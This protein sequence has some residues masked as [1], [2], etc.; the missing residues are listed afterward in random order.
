MVDVTT[1]LLGDLTENVNLLQPTGVAVTISKTNYP[2]LQFFAQ[3]VTIPSLS[4]PEAE[5]GYPRVNLPLPGDKITFDD[6]QFSILVDED[7]NS[8]LELFSWLYRLINEE[9]KLPSD[10]LRT[11]IASEADITVNILT[12]QN[13]GNKQFKFYGAFPTSLGSIELSSQR[14]DVEPLVFTAGFKFAYFEIR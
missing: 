6:V 14:N 2:N 3:S 13:N 11:G 12:S 7:M 10:V 1:G 4:L 8:Y 5:V 9:Q